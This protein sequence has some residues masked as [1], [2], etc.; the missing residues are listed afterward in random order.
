MSVR[1]LE[2]AAVL[3]SVREGISVELRGSWGSGRSALL[4][5]V[6]RAARDEGYDTLAVTGENALHAHPLEALELAGIRPALPRIG[7]AGRAGSAISARVDALTARVLG[8]PTL[9]LVDD[10]AAL[11]PESWGV[12]AAVQRRTNVAVVYALDAHAPEGAGAVH[13]L[14]RRVVRV[15]L[16]PLRYEEVRTLLE[17]ELG[18]GVDAHTA[19]RVFTKSGGLPR[20]VLAVAR[21]GRQH[22]I[23]VE[24]DGVWHAGDDLWHAALAPHLTEILY[25]LTAA[26]REGLEMLALAGI[27]PVER[28]ARVVGS[29]V[30]EQLEARDLVV[31]F[32]NGTRVMVAVNPPL[33]AEYYRHQSISA[34]RVRLSERI[35]GEWGVPASVAGVGAAES[36]GRPAA[37][38]WEAVRN[39][40]VARLMSEHRRADASHALDAWRAH[41]DAV[42]ALAVAE[43]FAAGAN[44]DRDGRD[45]SIVGAALD[46]LDGSVENPHVGLALL[47]HRLNR[48]LE[49]PR[50]G[51]RMR[52]IGEVVEQA[53]ARMPAQSGGVE[54]LALEAEVRGD[55]FS[56]ERERRLDE[57]LARRLGGRL[58]A[59]DAA[60]GG[61]TARDEGAVALAEAA[62]ARGWFDRA[63]TM[64][65]IA[66]ATGTTGA[67]E[68]ADTGG[69][70][71]ESAHWRRRR[72]RVA[73]LALFCSGRID[74]ALHRSAGWRDAALAE[75]DAAAIRDQSYVCALAL[76]HVGRNADADEAIGAALALGPPGRSAG[77]VYGAIL[78]LGAIVAA[79]RGSLG[80][81]R[82]LADQARAWIS[83][84]SPLPLA[85]PAFADAQ[86]ALARGDEKRARRSLVAAQADFTRRG[87]SVQAAVA[88]VMALEGVPDTAAVPHTAPMEG[89]L[90]GPLLDYL[91]G[92][93]GAEAEWI[94]A[95]ADRLRAADQVVHAAGAYLRAADAYRLAGRHDDADRV[96]E[97]AHVLGGALDADVL[98]YVHAEAAS[99]PALT[100]REREIT[101]LA[102]AGTTNQVI[103]ARLTVSVR[104]VENHL[105][106]AFRKLGISRREELESVRGLWA[107]PHEA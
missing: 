25:P 38:E 71:H 16:E 58:G 8:R 52:L 90:F 18:G 3:S 12:I 11:D 15:A 104:T 28:C 55:G 49:S 36:A 13:V 65:G 99:R 61:A 68:L 37:L 83:E 42:S 82:T 101:T 81:A 48:A 60:G 32:R 23:L 4:R 79:R 56:A 89:A 94:E 54:A 72:R 47:A 93:G 41:P 96:D 7:G 24:R 50:R 98:R 80:V 95:A 44:D 2:L 74:E 30:L 33:I 17:N 20:L 67:A 76:V 27:I 88:E 75:L 40:A 26:L 63:L 87:Y 86:I 14:E 53:R 69:P 73:A 21:T 92:V 45:D 57:M 51:E 97:S 39:P 70:A 59:G 66:G 46:A 29:A 64:L 107:Q 84:P 102:A 5:D 22:G 78:V 85:A 105:N 100:L 34:R 19:G 35:A 10:A 9:I 6:A 43:A 62:L 91:R 31:V 106:R 77:E 103:A 1:R